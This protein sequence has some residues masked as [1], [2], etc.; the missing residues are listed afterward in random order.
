[1]FWERA[2]D[3]KRTEIARELSKLQERN[4]AFQEARLDFGAERWGLASASNATNTTVNQAASP[5]ANADNEAI[6]DGG[7]GSMGDSPVAGEHVM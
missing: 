5:S 2:G 3:V 7:A 4:D 1:M 6:V